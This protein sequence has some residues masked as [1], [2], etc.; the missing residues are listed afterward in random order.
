MFV[1]DELSLPL[2]EI[3]LGLVV[4]DNS[5][6]VAARARCETHVKS[7]IDILWWHYPRFI[8]AGPHY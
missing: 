5:M 6:F 3:C 8:Q 4:R 2:W 7:S 1:K